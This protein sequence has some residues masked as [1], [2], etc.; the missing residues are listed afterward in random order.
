[1]LSGTCCEC[2]GLIRF[3]IS[4]AAVLL[5]TNHVGC[6]TLT[7]IYILLLQLPAWCCPGLSVVISPLLSLI[8]DQV[9]SMTKL[10]VQS[11]FLASSQDYES[12]QRDITRRLNTLSA[13]DGVKLLYLTPE[14]LSN[15]SMMQGLLR[16][17]HSKS[18]IS[19]FVVDEAHCLS[20][21][22]HDFRPDYNKLG[23]LRR[24]YPGVPL[25]ALTATANAKVVN[26]AI[27]A[28]DM[29]NEFRYKSS[30]NR[31][32]LRYEVRNK[33]G[34]TINSIADY[35]SKRPSESGVIYCLSRKDCENLAEKLQ[36][37]VRSKPDCRNV[38]VSFYHAELDAHERERRHSEWS[39]GII[40]VLCATIA[41]GMGIDKPDVRYVIHYSMPK[42]ITHYYQ[43]SG[44]AGRDGDIADCILYY[45]YKDKKIL[46][47]MIIKSSNDPYGQATRRKVDQLYACVGYCEDEF[48]CRRT[49]Q[50]DFFGETFDRTKC[51][52]TCDN[53][54]A[55]REPDRR[56]MTDTA[57]EII[58][59]FEDATIQKRDA[60]LTLLQLSD[61]Y[62]GGKSQSVT[63]FLNTSK[64]RGYGAGSK[65]KRN[66]IDRITHAMIF[67]RII[68]EES[69]ENTGGFNSDY[70]R[71]AE[72]AIAVKNGQHQFYVNFPKHKTATTNVVDTEKEN[73]TNSK[74]PKADE[75][76]SKKG[77]AT[78][79]RGAS[80]P[81]Q[82]KHDV[83]SRKY[84][85]RIERE[86]V[87]IDESTSSDD[88]DDDDD[89]DNDVIELL[90]TRGG[91]SSIGIKA[92][93]ILPYEAT[94]G[95]ISRIKTLATNWAE[96]ERMCGNNMFYWNILSNDV[97]KTIAA[98]VPM[99]L[100]ALKSIGCLG[101]NI[102]KE[103]GERI[104]KIVSSY[105]T[106]EGL[107]EYI[108]QR[109][110]QLPNKKSKIDPSTSTSEIVDLNDVNDE[111]EIGIDLSTIDSPMLA[112]TR[113][114]ALPTKKVGKG[115]RYFE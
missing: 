100:S 67:D 12:E 70:V 2:A 89:D 53:C 66:D 103:Y 47:N 24:E 79:K 115:S 62:R 109:D 108:K 112:N 113:A 114:A 44:R 14:K 27:R 95:L 19:R 48:S 9:Q 13:H 7:E 31:P 36:E 30:F 83:D 21:W 91:R 1:M 82:T 87:C 58:Q 15:S 64:L 68:V 43:E 111:F 26:D 16:R 72:N 104:V 97:M 45:N 98:E 93:S 34:K 60:R 42:S 55:Q 92:N 38:R 4:I 69:A 28:L 8:Q 49:L 76:K 71:L 63:K 35:I 22:G 107:E 96:E 51:N 65:Y 3:C 23:M 80:A 75:T 99:T 110:D 56:N 74:K 81:V 20:D 33:D 52:R 25:M 84:S 101:E 90:S 88:I 86:T 37:Q 5:F 105:I 85:A 57:R 59:L 17:L 18:L 29:Q 6:T 77:S 40:S 106:Q 39:N 54:K 32:N 78:K 61:L 46:E 41:F 94:Q 73:K 50:L 11:V 10:G 102:I